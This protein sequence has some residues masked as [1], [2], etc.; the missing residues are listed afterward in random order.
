M[1]KAGSALSGEN[2]SQ[3]ARLKPSFGGE[4]LIS[5]AAKRED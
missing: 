4:R 3:G 1:S 2:G 5:T